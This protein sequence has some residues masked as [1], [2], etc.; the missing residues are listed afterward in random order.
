[1]HW[2]PRPEPWAAVETEYPAGMPEHHICL[3]VAYDEREQAQRLSTELYAACRQ[4][5][6]EALAACAKSNPHCRQAAALQRQLLAARAEQRATERTIAELRRNEDLVVH[7]HGVVGLSTL[8]RDQA[9]ADAL[10]SVQSATIQKMEAV[11]GELLGKAR[12]AMQRAAAGAGTAR[13]HELNA[14]RRQLVE[15]VAQVCGAEL[16]ELLSCDLERQH[17]SAVA[18]NSPVTD[19]RMLALLSA[20]DAPK[21]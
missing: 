4:G 3:Q 15:R 7:G 21:L 17:L 8:F 2:Q 14:R 11:H 13:V 5:V 20:S 19:G 9:S 1:V 6:E 18:L 12:Q 10:S 16:D